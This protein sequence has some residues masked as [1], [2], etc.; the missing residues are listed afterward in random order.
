MKVWVTRL[1]KSPKP[2]KVIPVD[3]KYLKWMMEDR[4]TTSHCPSVTGNIDDPIQLLIMYME[5]MELLPNPARSGSVWC[6]RYSYRNVPSGILLR[7][8][9]AGST[10]D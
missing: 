1:G 5:V 6:K 2:A 9:V 8:L 3:E 7:E 10:A 4:V